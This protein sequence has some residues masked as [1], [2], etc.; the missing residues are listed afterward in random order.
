[1]NRHVFIKGMAL[2]LAAGS[3]LGMIC[4]PRRKKT[5]VHRALKTVSS[6]AGELG[7]CLGL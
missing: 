1:M 3:A 5:A 7:D 6:L 4:A 2:G